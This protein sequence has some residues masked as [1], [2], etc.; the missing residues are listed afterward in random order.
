MGPRCGAPRRSLKG[1]GWV[2]FNACCGATPHR[3]AVNGINGAFYI[4]E[5]FAM[6][7]ARLRRSSGG[8]SEASMHAV[9]RRQGAGSPVPARGLRRFNP[10]TR[11]ERSRARQAKN[12]PSGS[13]HT[14][15]FGQIG[16]G[17]LELRCSHN[18]NG[19]DSRS[20]LE[21]PNLETDSN[22][23]PREVT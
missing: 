3:I 16:A 9:R 13:A 19:G 23:K 10:V 17:H 14:V 12:F 20:S 18:A 5:R 6:D 22:R 8:R 21:V 15:G 7:F 1:A 4:A 11:S 2:A